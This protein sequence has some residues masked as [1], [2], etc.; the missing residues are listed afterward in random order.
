MVRASEVRA[1]S[2]MTKGP[3]RL[4]LEL[5]TK[6]RSFGFLN[7]RYFHTYKYYKNLRSIRF[8]T[9]V[10]LILRRRESQTEF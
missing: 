4:R 2:A 6:L 3:H 5:C 8:N 9:K 1:E 7:E 10:E